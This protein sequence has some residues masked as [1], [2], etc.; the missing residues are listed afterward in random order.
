MLI[1]RSVD[2]GTTSKNQ[3]LALETRKHNAN[4]IN[5]NPL[6]YANSRKSSHKHTEQTNNPQRRNAATPQP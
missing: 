1:N 3:I 6:Y 2:K 4:Q 5:K